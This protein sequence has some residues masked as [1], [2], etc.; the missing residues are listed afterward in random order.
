MTPFSGFA[1]TG[2]QFTFFCDPD[3]VPLEIYTIL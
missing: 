1:L 2:K 3:N